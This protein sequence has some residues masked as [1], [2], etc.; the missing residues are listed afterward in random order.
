MGVKDDATQW[1]METEAVMPS[2]V[3]MWSDAIGRKK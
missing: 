1:A 3:A 2:S